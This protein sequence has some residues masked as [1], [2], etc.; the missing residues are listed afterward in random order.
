MKAV[1]SALRVS[2]HTSSTVQFTPTRLECVRVKTGHDF[3]ELAIVR[4][5]YRYLVFLF[6]CLR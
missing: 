4:E 1:V 3:K 5:L 6:F 2:G